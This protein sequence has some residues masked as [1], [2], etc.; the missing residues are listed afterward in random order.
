MRGKAREEWRRGVC[1]T[2]RK[3]EGGKGE[4]RRRGRKTSQVCTIFIQTDRG[5]VCPGLH[6]PSFLSLSVP[7]SHPLF[8]SLSLSHTHSF[9]LS[10]SLCLSRQ[11]AVSSS[12]MKKTLKSYW[13]GKRK[14]KQCDKH[15]TA[16]QRE[17]R[18]YRE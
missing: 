9:S 1:E 12:K 11:S 15:Q 10:L 13:G 7:L 4:Q 8:L 14:G 16:E 6:F 2:D 5:C 17:N 18:M 3:R